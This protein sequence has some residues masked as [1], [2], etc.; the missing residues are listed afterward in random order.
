[1]YFNNK[2]INVPF[3]KKP[4]PFFKKPLCL[5][6][7]FISLIS[8]YFSFICCL[9]ISLLKKLKQQSRET[10]EERRPQLTAALQEVCAPKSDQ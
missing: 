9:V 3:F 5:A 8:P 2:G 6:C 10:L 7:L 1:M 4:V